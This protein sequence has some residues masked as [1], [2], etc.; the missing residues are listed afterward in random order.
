MATLTAN[1]ASAGVQPHG[2][3]VG[4]VSTTATFSANGSMSSGDV[5]QMIKVP[6][7]S[8][9]VYL[10]TGYQLSGVGSIV[11]GDGV[12]TDRYL[13]ATAASAGVGP[14]SAMPQ[15]LVPYTYSTDDTIDVIV[16]MSVNVSS[17][18]IYMIAVVN[19]DP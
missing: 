9:V 7:N 3:R 4:L 16:S 2:I 15:A 1:K 19:L 17:G 5:V 14:F 11:I 12:D 18:A 8:Q 6:Q 13:T 10:W